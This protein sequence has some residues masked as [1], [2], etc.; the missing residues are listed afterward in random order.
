MNSTDCVVRLSWDGFAALCRDLAERVAA[1]YDPEIVVGIARAGTLPAALIALLL[2][3]DFQTLRVPVSSQPLVLP[4]YLPE[5]RV[6]AG[7]RVLLIDERAPDDTALCWAA[8]ALRALGAREVRTL[9]MFVADG[10]ASADY[11]GP[12]VGALV[13]QPWIRDTLVT[14]T[15]LPGVRPSGR[16]NE[17]QTPPAPARS[18]PTRT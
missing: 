12:E 4:S 11:A 1:D 13:L 16:P 5:R 7:R 10:G 8:G 15:V 17:Q 3:L 2:R 6:L 18:S 14:H 9:V